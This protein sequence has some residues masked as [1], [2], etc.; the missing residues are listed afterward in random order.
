MGSFTIV[1]LW[2][3]DPGL[4]T[5]RARDLLLATP[6]VIVPPVDHP[7]VRWLESLGHEVILLGSLLGREGQTSIEA[8]SAAVLDR[9]RLRDSTVL[10]TAGHPLLDSHENRSIAINAEANGIDVRIIPA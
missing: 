9:V 8:L 2:P 5:V 1:G 4:L 10:A 6:E 7:A 3:G